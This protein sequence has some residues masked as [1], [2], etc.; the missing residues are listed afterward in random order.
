MFNK[1]E[2]QDTLTSLLG[3]L[4]DPERD[5]LAAAAYTHTYLDDRTLNTAYKSS[6]MIK[7]AVNIPAHDAT[8]KWRTWQA[9]NSDAD[10]MVQTEIMFDLKRKVRTAKVQARLFGGS[11]IMIGTNDNDL[12]KPLDPASVP[13]GGLKYLSVVPRRELSAAQLVRDPAD[14]LFGCPE[15]YGYNSGYGDGAHSHVQIHPTRLAIFEGVECVDPWGT[16][17]TAMGWGDSV[18]NALYEA[19]KQG[20]STLANI[21]SLVFEANVDVVKIPDLMA[22]SIDPEY[23]KKFLTRIRLAAAAKGINRMLVLDTLEEYERKSAN[24]S[25][26]DKIIDQMLRMC[27]GAADIPFTR[28]MSQSPAGLSS[29]GEGDMKNYYDM[30]QTIQNTELTPSMAMLDRVLQRTTFG[31]EPEGITSTW[32]ALEQMSEKEQAEIGKMHA[33]TA[34]SFIMAGMYSADEME[35]AVTPVLSDLGVYPNLSSIMEDAPDRD[36]DDGDLG[37]GDPLDVDDASSPPKPLYVYRQV[38]N[39]QAIKDHY[40]AQGVKVTLDVDDLHVTIVYSR[41]AVDWLKMGSPWEAELKVPEGGP[42]VMQQ[43]NDAVVLSFANSELEWRQ[44]RMVREGASFDYEEYTPHVT[45]SY[46]EDVDL[47]TIEAYQGEIILGP[48]V[49][50]E[51]DTEYKPG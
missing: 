50:Q 49:F 32:A 16:Y 8:R 34:S 29:T 1:I 37:G 27:A 12:S 13:R 11:A 31:A 7:K 6:W 47:G 15:Y 9:D 43:F 41:R 40:E 5:K 20:D 44:D 51:L 35:K 2:M 4:G 25:G 42:R 3:G 28:F 22:S 36:A 45:I 19:M 39:G 30:V 10:K 17:G 48:E 18:V 14:P 46:G 33:E 23:E 26:L 38:L 21:A 24:F